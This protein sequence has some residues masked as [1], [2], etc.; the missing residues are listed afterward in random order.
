[1]PDVSTEV[2][3]ATQTLGTAANTIT[4]S[5]IPATYTNL[6]L[7]IVSLSSTTNAQFVQVNNDT[8]TNYSLTALYGNGA[9]ASTYALTSAVRWDV[10]SEI[11]GGSSTIPFLIEMEFFSYAGSTN[12]TV[13][14]KSS[15]DLNGSG[16]TIC[17]VGLYR[18]TSAINR[19]DIKRTAG[20]YNIGTTATL[21]GIL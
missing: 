10:A 6:R 16:A 5:S 4:F 8:A 11:V 3:I 1:M 14:F 21:Y 20:N 7:V 9:S 13:L 2:A 12:K 18:S 17:K 19:I 15:E